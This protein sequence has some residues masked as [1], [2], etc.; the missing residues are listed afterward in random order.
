MYTTLIQVSADDKPR[1]WTASVGIDH[2]Q[3]AMPAGQ[4]DVARRFYT[5]VLGIPEVPKP[6]VLAARGGCWFE[7][8]AVRVHLGVED[9]FRPARKA[10]PA[11]VVADLRSFVERP[12]STS[13][14]PTTSPAP[15]AAT[16]PTRSATASS[17]STAAG[18]TREADPL[19][20]DRRRAAR[21]GRGQRA[22]GSLLPSESELSARFGA[23]RVTVRRA[24]ELVRDEGLIAARQGFG[25]FVA[26]EPVRQRLEHLG[27]I[28]DQ[29]EGGGRHAERRVTEFAFV[30]A[31]GA[32][33]PDPR[34]RPGAAG[35]AAQP[36]RRRAVRR[37]HRVVPGRARARSLSREDV[38][39]RP[40]Y[41]LL[42]DPAARGDADDRRRLRRAGR[43]RA[44]ARPGRRAAAALPAGHD[45]HQRPPGPDERAPVPGPPHRVRRRAPVRR[46]V[47]SAPPA[48][49]SSS[50][51]PGLDCRRRSVPRNVDSSEDVHERS[52][53]STVGGDRRVSRRG[54]G[55]R[56]RSG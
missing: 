13:R 23:S 10:H 34:R 25:W 29:L 15:S 35:Q 45:R 47:A 9:D 11:L 24:L 52:L 32:R 8:G 42:G 21:A 37:R 18:V 12:G 14:G 27:T 43:R 36:R 50:R 39:R 40:F 4:E 44:A 30:G 38:E 33:A 2:V 28:E 6:P 7:A 51:P 49:A 20:G 31:A 22:A 1:R 55:R 56:R 3:L 48:S 46:T 54:G 53:A 41:E 19:P 5:G 16:S 26:T 17:S